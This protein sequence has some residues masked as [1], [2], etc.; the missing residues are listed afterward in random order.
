MS[1]YIITRKDFMDINVGWENLNT[2]EYILYNSIYMKFKNRPS[3]SMFILI[4]RVV[5]FE[6]GL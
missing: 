3:E 5:T 4:K 1:R 2:K 6:E